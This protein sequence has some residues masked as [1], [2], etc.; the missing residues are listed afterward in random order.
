[1]GSG[2]LLL[3]GAKYPSHDGETWWLSGSIWSKYPSGID[4]S[5]MSDATAIAGDKVAMATAGD[6]V[7]LFDG[8]N[9]WTARIKGRTESRAHPGDGATP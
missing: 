2:L 1:V 4:D 8:A 7:V 6:K 9:T 5:Q 3:G